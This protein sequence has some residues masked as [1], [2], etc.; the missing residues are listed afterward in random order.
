MKR[1]PALLA[2]LWIA[3]LLSGCANRYPLD[4]PEEQWETMTSEQR[5]EARRQQAAL[6]QARA[7]Q[8]TAQARAREEEA[9]RRRAE[10]EVRRQEAGF[11]ERVQC[12]LSHA[13]AHLGGSWQ[14]VQPLAL[15]VVQGMEVGFEIQAVEDD[16]VR[17]Q[18]KGYAHFDGT[19]LTLCPRPD[20]YQDH[21]AACAQLVGTTNDYR[22]GLRG[23]VEGHRFLRGR[24]RCDLHPA[25]AVLHRR[26]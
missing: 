15:D 5:L 3:V 7:E 4:I 25:S 24:L 12:V 20:Q 6:D 23:Q 26:Q 19:R 9:A 21:A 17:W 11:G 2:S 22:R 8:R 18:D 13:R 14:S 16:W 10:L 1:L